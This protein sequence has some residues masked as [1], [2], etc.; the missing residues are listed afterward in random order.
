MWFLTKSQGMKQLRVTLSKQV[1]L[2][3]LVAPPHCFTLKCRCWFSSQTCQWISEKKS[4]APWWSETGKTA[5]GP[6][7]A[8]PLVCRCNSTTFQTQKM[9]Q[10]YKFHLDKYLQRTSVSKQGRN[11]V[12]LHCSSSSFWLLHS[13]VRPCFIITFYFFIQESYRCTSIFLVW[14]LLICHF[15][16]LHHTCFTQMKTWRFTSELG[17]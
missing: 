15:G 6:A 5:R 4:L 1:Y 3:A 14:H 12:R 17:Q 10:Q 16:T 2:Y 8:W 11:V 9:Q 7:R 13:K